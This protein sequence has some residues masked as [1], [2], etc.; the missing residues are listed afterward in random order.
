M[1]MSLKQRLAMLVLPVAILVSSSAFAAVILPAL[2]IQDFG[3]DTGVELS[4]SNFNI[5]AT[6]FKIITDGADIDIADEAFTLTST[7]VFDSGFGSFSGSFIVGGGLLEGSVDNLTVLS[8]GGVDA[9]FGG[10]LTYTGG[11]LMGGLAGG[12]IEGVLSG[13]DVVAKLGVVVPVPAAVWLFGSGLIGL[14][15]IARRKVK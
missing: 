10:D 15:G 14:A 7:G 4:T 5:D 6:V 11:S 13:N 12:R 3:S 8:L 1:G 9:S 2:D